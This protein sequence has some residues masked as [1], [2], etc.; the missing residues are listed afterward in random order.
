MKP[1]AN[2]ERSKVKRHPPRRISQW[3]TG[4]DIC[5]PSFASCI[6]THMHTI[7]LLTS[8]EQDFTESI[9]TFAFT[10]WHH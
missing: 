10:P 8:T 1:L 6:H 2:S 9:T 5:T 7:V 4:E 3:G